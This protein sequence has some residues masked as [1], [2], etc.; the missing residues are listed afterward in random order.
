MILIAG[1]DSFVFG[2]ELKDQIDGHSLSTYSALLA[3][4]FD[5]EY[6]CAAWVGNAN[7]A[8]NRMTMS[9][10]DQHLQNDKKIGVIVT[11]TFTNRY[12]FR[13]NYATGHR[14]SPWHSINAWSTYDDATLIQ[15]EFKDSNW[16]TLYEQMQNLSIGKKSG[17]AD[18]SKIW[19]KH[20]GDSEYYELYSSLKEI[21]LLQFYLEHNHVPYLFLTADNHFYEHPNY[22]RQRDAYIDMLYKKINWSKWFF[23]AP[24]KNA[25]ETQEPRGFYQWAAENKYPIGTTHPLEEAHLAAADLLKDKFNELVKRPLLQN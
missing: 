15:K 24:G 7:A 13:F 21:L 20:V 16:F 18:F 25:N 6:Q 11:W 9:A 3:K 22:F 12:E 2:S 8:I 19:Y 17:T 10:C 14:I 4:N 1:G 5:L 23:F